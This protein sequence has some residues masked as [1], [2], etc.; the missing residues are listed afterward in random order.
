MVCIHFSLQYQNK[1]FLNY[2]GVG[3]TCHYRRSARSRGLLPRMWLL[4][5]GPRPRGPVA[6][7]GRGQMC[8]GCWPESTPTGPEPPE[9]L[10]L[11][12]ASWDPSQ[13]E[14]ELADR[15]REVSDSSQ[16]ASGPRS[17]LPR[18]WALW[19]AP[20]PLPA[21]QQWGPRI[22]TVG[23]L[24]LGECAEELGSWGA[25]PSLGLCFYKWGTWSSLA[26]HGRQGAGRLPPTGPK[27]QGASA[28]PS[29]PRW[30]D[31]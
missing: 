7:V 27:P 3:E 31:H 26:C 5:G 9:A 22:I 13:G 25:P 24:S 16:D 12:S 28:M 8:W 17:C 20:C 4:G 6:P 11:G 10:L 19:P 18:F 15:P 29:A 21:C 2:P 23:R 1:L 30:G 14:Q